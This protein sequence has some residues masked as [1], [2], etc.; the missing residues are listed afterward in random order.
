VRTFAG[1]AFDDGG[2]DATAAAGHQS[3]FGNRSPGIL[4]E[5]MAGL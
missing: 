1:K 5:N 3:P 4:P 2:S